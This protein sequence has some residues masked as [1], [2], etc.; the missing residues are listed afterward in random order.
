MKGVALERARD[1]GSCGAGVAILLAHVTSVIRSPTLLPESG[2][3]IKRHP[4]QV[5][6]RERKE[7]AKNGVTTIVVTELIEYQ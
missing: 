4:N 6:V 1:V 2:R 5:S 7:C 3:S